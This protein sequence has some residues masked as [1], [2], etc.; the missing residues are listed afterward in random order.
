MAL[1][2]KPA[3]MVLLSWTACLAHAGT[4]GVQVKDAAGKPL[5]DA[6]VFLE[7]PAARAAVKPAQGAEIAQ[8]SKQFVPTVTVVPVGS[9]VLFPNRDTVRHHVY[10]FSPAK[11][12]ELK[13]YTGT[14]A[15]PVLFDKPGVVILGCNI[16]DHMIAWVLVVE[17]PYYGK[18][19]AEGMLALPGV[20]PGSYRLRT[21]HSVLPVGAIPQDQGL[22][23]SAADTTVSVALKVAAP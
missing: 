21:W 15:N 4:V 2:L 1:R 11:T 9:S 20:A 22:A 10:S 16:H 14:P 17:T 8:A 12:F 5:A 23:V 7:S 3:L 13:L 19:N 6:I 18:T